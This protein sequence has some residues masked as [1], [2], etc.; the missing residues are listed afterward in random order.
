MTALPLDGSSLTLDA[1]AVVARQGRKA[2]LSAKGRQQVADCH[3]LLQRMVADGT[4]IYGVTTG[5]GA[6]AG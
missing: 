2:E 6:L 5:F 1:V 4:P 3:A